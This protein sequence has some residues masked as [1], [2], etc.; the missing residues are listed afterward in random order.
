MAK[1]LL[2]VPP[3]AVIK[4]EPQKVIETK[5]IKDEQGKKQTSDVE[6]VK[7]PIELVSMD[8]LS[9]SFDG[10]SWSVE[11]RDVK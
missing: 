4:V 7:L 9:A 1:N 10:I 8:V 5:I 11:V 3:Q 6:I 2:D